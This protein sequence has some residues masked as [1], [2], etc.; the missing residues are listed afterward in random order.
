[1]LQIFT[2]DIWRFPKVIQVPPNHPIRPWLGRLIRIHQGTQGAALG[3]DPKAIKSW[4]AAQTALGTGVG[5]TLNRLVPVVQ[6]RSEAIYQD[7]H[8]YHDQWK[9]SQGRWK[10]RAYSTKLGTK[11]DR[12]EI[13]SLIWVCLKIWYLWIHWL[14]IMFLSKSTIW[15]VYTIFRQTHLEINRN[16]ESLS[17]INKIYPIR[18]PSP[19]HHRRPEVWSL[20]PCHQ[21]SR[22]TKASPAKLG[23]LPPNTCYLS[24]NDSFESKKPMSFVPLLR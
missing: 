20:T 24:V 2:N 8:R 13:K 19:I 14:I 6:Q 21:G 17:L 22:E 18:L 11:L 1:M 7:S 5:E 9:T 15:G 23:I 10:K 16:P 12:L 4:D 3:L